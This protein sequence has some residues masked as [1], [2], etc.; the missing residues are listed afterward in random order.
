MDGDYYQ[1]TSDLD[2]R[3]VL[4]YLNNLGIHNISGEVLKY[5]ITDLKKLIK[6]D[7]QNRNK[8][9]NE[10]EEFEVQWSERLYSASTFSS[11]TKSKS[12]EGIVPCSKE[13][14]K[15]KR[16]HRVQNI[17]NVY[18]APNLGPI[19]SDDKPVRRACSCVRNE[20][21]PDIKEKEKITVNTN[22]L[23]K[24]QKQPVKKKCDPVSLYHYYTSLWAKYKPN[25]PGE[26]DWSELRWS[27]RQKMAGNYP[28]QTVNKVSGTQASE[29]DGTL[30]N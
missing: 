24:V 5:F 29:K 10:H 28:R 30:R 4:R 25:V 2:A 20:T 27:V 8:D 11:R 3:Q 16:L 22:N 23:I 15:T 13:C 18:S 1:I 6:Y 17:R 12:Q 21:K 7:L 26:N 19:K 14:Q 9:K